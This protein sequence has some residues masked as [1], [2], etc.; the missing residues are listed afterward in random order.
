MDTIRRNVCLNDIPAAV[1]EIA[2]EAA[3]HLAKHE[4]QSRT[5]LKDILSRK[6]FEAFLDKLLELKESPA[7]EACTSCWT[8]RS[9]RI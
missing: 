4:L 8:F 5:P 6:Q 1:A 2:G 3:S 7:S 9:I